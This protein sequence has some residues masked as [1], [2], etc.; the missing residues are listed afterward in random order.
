M[1]R[2]SSEGEKFVISA[3]EVRDTSYRDAIKL[4]SATLKGAC[5]VEEDGKFIAENGNST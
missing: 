4:D 5:Q 1:C 3:R 2:C